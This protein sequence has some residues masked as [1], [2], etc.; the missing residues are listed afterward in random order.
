MCKKKTS[1]RKLTLAK[2]RIVDEEI[3]DSTHTATTYLEK[4][5]T[6]D[7]IHKKLESLL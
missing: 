3:R 6:S 2:K 5:A 1:K 4:L 7:P